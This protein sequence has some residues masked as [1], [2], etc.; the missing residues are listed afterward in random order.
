MDEHAQDP[1]GYYVYRDSETGTFV[2]GAFAKRNPKT[3]QREWIKVPDDQ[4]PDE[5]AIMHAIRYGKR[6]TDPENVAEYFM[7][8]H[9][10]V[11]RVYADKMRGMER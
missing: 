11:Q 2:S 8:A 3:T 6:E 9:S 4:D 10:I 7:D 1:R 5:L